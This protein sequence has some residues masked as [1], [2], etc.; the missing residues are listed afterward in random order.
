[1]E[2]RI[3]LH[4]RSSGASKNCSINKRGELL[5]EEKMMKEQN[6]SS[7]SRDDGSEFPEKKTTYI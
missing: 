6:E 3:E 2:E 5:G 7:R 1:M 4:S